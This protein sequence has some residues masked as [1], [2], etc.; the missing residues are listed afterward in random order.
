MAISNLLYSFAIIVAGLLLG[1]TLQALAVRG[2]IRLP[3]SIDALRKGLQR[4]A[5]LFVNPA[6][7]LGATWIV[8]IRD[9]TLA[10]LPFVGLFAIATGGVLALGAARLLHLPPKKTGALFCC[11]SFTNIGSIGALV[12][13]V[14]L[15]EPGFALVPVYKIF[16]ELSYYS[17]GFPI[18]KY[19]SGSSLAEGRWDRVKGL[20]RDPLILVSVSS[21]L[22]GGALNA[23]G[24]ERPAIYGTVNAVFIPLAAFMLLISVGLALRFRRVGGYLR[25]AAAVSA[26][27]FAAV[28]VLASTL[29]WSLGFG[30]IDGGLPLK[31]VMILSS[32]PVAF[33]ALIP[34]SIYDLDLDLANS[35]WFVTTALLAIILPVL[36][37]L[38]QSF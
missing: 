19:Y 25:E 38:I 14:F 32:M 34:P 3:L 6:A 33:N 11:G 1:Y 24:L 26:I 2:F 20:I 8:S 37:F 10:A 7:I 22:L 36:L 31:V 29:A 13:Y 12:C 16:E 27:K 30:R 21:L 5:L 17:T 15:G 4:A 23:S 35:C 18:A 9:A 28:P